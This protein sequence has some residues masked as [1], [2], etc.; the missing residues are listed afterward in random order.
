MSRLLSRSDFHRWRQGAVSTMQLP[1]GRNGLESYAISPVHDNLTVNLD[2]ISRLPATD[3][4]I[5]MVEYC[6]YVSSNNLKPMT[7]TTNF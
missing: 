3:A 6:V 4:F 7:Q 5:S 1:S 2:Q